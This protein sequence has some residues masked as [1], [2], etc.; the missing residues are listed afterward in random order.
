MDNELV[1]SRKKKAIV[2]EELRQRKYEGFPRGQD[3]KTKSEDD[4]EGNV[5]EP[6]EVETDGP[7][8]AYDYLLSVSCHIT[9]HLEYF[10]YH[11]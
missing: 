1:V 2:V 11:V 9:T 4:E 10:A 5:E 8:N 7:A 6:E 3:K